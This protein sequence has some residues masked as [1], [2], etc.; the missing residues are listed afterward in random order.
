MSWNITLL[1]KHLVVLTTIGT[2]LKKRNDNTS[3]LELKLKKKKKKV[4]Y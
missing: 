2:K 3:N 4:C 1:L